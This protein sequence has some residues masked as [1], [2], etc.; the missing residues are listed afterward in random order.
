MS[1]VVPG[2]IERSIQ[3]AAPLARIWGLVAEPGWWINDGQIAEHTIT[4]DGDV[5]TVLDPTHGEFTIRLVE[6]REPEYVAYGWLAGT[7]EDQEQPLNTLIEFF[8]T[9]QLEGV[10]VRVVESGWAAL[11]QTDRMRDNFAENTAGWEQELAVA[12]AHLQDR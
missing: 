6:Q 4:W 7:S 1:D 2:C 12:R 8:L 10:E 9:E 5:A 11:E 3:I